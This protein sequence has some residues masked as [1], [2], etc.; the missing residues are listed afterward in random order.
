MKSLDFDIS[1]VHPKAT[2]R[3][4]DNPPEICERFRE[5]GFNGVMPTLAYVGPNPLLASSSNMAGLLWRKHLTNSRFTLVTVCVVITGG[6]GYVDYLTGYEQTFL[7]FYLVRIGLGTWFGDFW[8]GF[9]FSVMSIGAW[10]VSD[11]AA[12]VATLAV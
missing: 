4:G 9:T 12:G 8:L 5:I 10:V 2:L 7:L 1:E 11:V 6:L 3:Q